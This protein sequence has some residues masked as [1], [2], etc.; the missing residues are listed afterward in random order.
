MAM[1]EKLMADDI[2]ASIRA[3]MKTIHPDAQP[4]EFQEDLA[5][6]IAAA[7]I[8]QIKK[9]STIGSSAGFTA[10]GQPG[11]GISTSSSTMA[12]V[13]I[14]SMRSFLG[15]RGGIALEKYMNAIMIP[16]SKRLSSDVEIISI[17]GY[18]GSPIPPIGVTSATIEPAIFSNLPAR[19]QLYI[20][21]SRQ[22]RFFLKAIANGLGAGISAGTVGII[23]NA[24]SVENMNVLQGI[25]K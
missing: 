1:V 17:N 5:R 13:S 2:V 4:R 20:S 19:S 22:G 21:Q 3:N 8:G 10:T 11:Q 24:G 12:Q 7:V 15:T 23:P 25:F 16:V 9:A 18:G 6:A 14:A